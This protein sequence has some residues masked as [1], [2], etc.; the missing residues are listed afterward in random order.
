MSRKVIRKEFEPNECFIDDDGVMR[1]VL[2]GEHT[3]ELNRILCGI[4]RRESSKLRAAGKP[5]MMMVD[6]ND[7]KN[8]TMASRR[9]AASESLRLDV[10]G[11]AYSGGKNTW[12]SALLKFVL[13]MFD[14]ERFRYFDNEAAARAWLHTR[15]H[16][17][18]KK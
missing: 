7:L 1:F 11:L 12:S 3:L 13:T 10:D 14:K 15:K 17:I 18:L 16:Y 8:A 5:V 2:H 9:S 6:I 4:V